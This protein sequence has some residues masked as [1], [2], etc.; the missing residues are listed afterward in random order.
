MLKKKITP[1]Q[2]LEIYGKQRLHV[3][4]FKNQKIKRN[5]TMKWTEDF[6]FSVFA[7]VE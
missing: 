4:G 7:L 5:A 6:F 3:K 1:Q 2:S